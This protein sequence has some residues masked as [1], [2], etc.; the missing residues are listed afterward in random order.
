MARLQPFIQRK[1]IEAMGRRTTL[2]PAIQEAILH[3]VADGVPYIQAAALAAVPERTAHLWRQRGEGLCP[4]RPATPLYVQF[5]QSLTHARARDE[6]RRIARIDQAGEGGTVVE[7]TTTTRTLKDGTT[8]TETRER[9]SKPDWRADAWHLERSRPD[10][11]GQ[12]LC[13]NVE[14]SVRRAA[15]KVA[16]EATA[17]GIPMTADE[18][19]EEAQA[20]LEEIDAEDEGN[21]QR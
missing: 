11:W 6:A 16:A 20:L 10:T 12:Q 21:I 9:Y 14:R 17:E 7:R 19:L 5:V 1:E 8:V 4:D 2:T 18:V 15:E 3:A 13:V